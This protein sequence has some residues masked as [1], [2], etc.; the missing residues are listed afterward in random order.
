MRPA[1]HLFRL[2]RGVLLSRRRFSGRFMR[3]MVRRLREQRCRRESQTYE[4]QSGNGGIQAHQISRGAERQSIFYLMGWTSI[5]VSNQA[6]SVYSS[7]TNIIV[8]AT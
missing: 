4:Y 7:V 5:S 3:N 2:L 8:E 6:D 1:R